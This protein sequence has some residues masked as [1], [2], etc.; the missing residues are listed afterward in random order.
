LSTAIEEDAVW[1]MA[2]ST[3]LTEILLNL[4]SNAIKFTELGG[5]I[6]VTVRRAEHGGIAFAVCDTGCGMSPAEIEIALEVF[7]QVDAG[8][9]RRHEGTGLG[10]PLAR[11][12][13]ELHGGSLVIASEKGR[14][15]TVTVMLPANRV[16]SAANDPSASGDMVFEAHAAMA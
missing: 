4:L 2:D 9:A 6:E 13:A 7:G 1:V 12:L 11:K 3:R 8:L 10:L 15:T 14:G 16:V 5:A